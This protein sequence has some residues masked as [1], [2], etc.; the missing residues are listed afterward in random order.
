MRIIL[1][2][3]VLSKKITIRRPEGVLKRFKQNKHL[4]FWIRLIPDRAGKRT[5]KP[6]YK[7][8]PVAKTVV[9]T[10]NAWNMYQIVPLK[11]TGCQKSFSNCPLRQKILTTNVWN[12]VYVTTM[13]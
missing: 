5:A 13:S 2:Q 4:S 6:S 9:I 12:A 7:K 10:H 3:Y 11:T 8:E 1:A